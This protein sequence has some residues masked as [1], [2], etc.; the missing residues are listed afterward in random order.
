MNGGTCGSDPGASDSNNDFFCICPEGFTGDNCEIIL[1]DECAS[2]PC[3]NGT[4][5]DQFDG[6]ICDCNEG[7]TGQNCQDFN[8]C[9]IED[10]CANG[11]CV[12]T[13]GSFICDCEDG[14]TGTYCGEGNI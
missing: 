11:V 6:Y 10:P 4:C 13:I 12:N 14:Y 2:S 8:E 7:Y 5:I 3:I 9:S 1:I